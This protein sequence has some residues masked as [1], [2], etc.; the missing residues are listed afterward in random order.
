MLAG[1]IH[2]L[3]GYLV[4]R[5]SGTFPE[6]FLNV[7][8]AQGILVRNVTRL[9]DNS[10]RLTISAH[11]F[12][13]LPP[14]AR[15]TGVRVKILRKCG[16]LPLLHKHRK[17]K[18]LFFG[19]CL[20]I[21]FFIGLNQFVWKIEIV[22]NETV[23]SRQI[24]EKL[25]QNGLY[26]GQF[27][28]HIN[29]KQVKNKMLIEM[30]ELSWLWP[31]KK[32]SKVIVTVK[33]KTPIPEIFDANDY[34]SIVAAKDGVIHSMIVRNGFPVIKVNDTVQKGSLLISGMLE[35]ERNVPTR[36]VH[37]E[38]EVYART[39][40]EKSRAFPLVGQN[41]K[42][43]GKI[44]TRR[45]LHLFGLEIPLFLNHEVPYEDYLAE[46]D[47]YELSLFGNYLGFSVVKQTYRE[48]TREEIRLAQDFV[49]EDGT[50][51][52]REEIDALTLPNSQLL[53]IEPTWRAIDED[54]VEVTVVA[55]Y[56]ENI[57]QKIKMERPPESA[58]TESVP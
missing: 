17:R 32:G 27:R 35:S 50:H 56:L 33:E 1:L 16:L 18:M 48:I 34:C 2:F 38:A 8:A 42:E 46:E 11:A 21:F 6:R 28:H 47:V 39:W 30:T 5:I 58:E 49:I 36:Y 44:V 29:Q 37:S 43:T 10:M 53:R 20:F 12:R 24:I 54:T 57:A 19:I 3:K 51:K 26:V 13:L 7:C 23:S 14:I 15:R 52:L 31:E 41:Q 4:I 45:K 9:S 55:E 25:K 40:Y 22:G